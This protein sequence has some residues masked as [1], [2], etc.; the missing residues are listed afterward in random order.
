MTHALANRTKT[1][2]PRAET[3]TKTAKSAERRPM[4]SLPP[5]DAKEL[6]KACSALLHNVT[7]MVQLRT[8]DFD[9]MIVF[10]SIA[11]L[12]VAREKVD[13]ATA[14]GDDDSYFSAF[15]AVGV[16]VGVLRH[17][18]DFTNDPILRGA[19]ILAQNAEKLSEQTCIGGVAAEQK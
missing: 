9:E 4:A 15:V 11:L 18:A 14:S 8:E 10:G 12:E 7:E 13:S 3:P 16:A 19:H 5:A 2:T 1:A 17:A 6:A